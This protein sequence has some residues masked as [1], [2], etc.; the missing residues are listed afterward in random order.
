MKCGSLGGRIFVPLLEHPD[1]KLR[2]T[3]NNFI[4]V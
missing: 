4:D 3:P 1:K 2:G